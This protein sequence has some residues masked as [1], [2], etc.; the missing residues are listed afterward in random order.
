MLK[1]VAFRASFGPIDIVF[2]LLA[3]ASAYKLGS[4]MA[5]GD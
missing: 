3:I 5:T 4:G 1:S 2:F